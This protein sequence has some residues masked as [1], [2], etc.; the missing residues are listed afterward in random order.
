[1]V[2]ITIL[3]SEKELQ[4]FPI[5]Q[6]ILL[7]SRTDIELTFLQDYILLFRVVPNSP[8]ISLAPPYSYSIGHIKERFDTIPLVFTKN[9]NEDGSFK[10]E[11][12]PKQ[13]LQPDSS[14]II[15][16][17]KDLAQPT[18]VVEKVVTKSNSTLKAYASPPSIERTLVVDVL[19]TSKLSGNSNV[20]SFEIDSKDFT[21]DLGAKLNLEYNNVLYTFTNTVYVQGE[22]F[23][24]GINPSSSNNLRED[25]LYQFKTVASTSIKPIEN[26]QPSQ[27]INTQSILDFY[28]KVNKTPKS[29]TSNPTYVAPNVIEIPIP[30]G[31]ILDEEKLIDLR[32]SPAFNNHVLNSLGLYTENPYDIYVYQDGSSLI[33][34]AILGEEDTRV[35]DDNEEVRPF[36]VSKR[37]FR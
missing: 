33:V 29:L 20:V 26:Q 7:K 28:K 31:Y 30:D 8:L 9:Q 34:E 11:V 14:Y 36:K 12:K 10:I 1:M 35:L 3:N 23:N 24:V 17:S 19:T 6:S 37:G 13:V 5:T 22:S 15:Y 4:S 16:L 18:T 25:S 2:D 32:I 21:L 27:S